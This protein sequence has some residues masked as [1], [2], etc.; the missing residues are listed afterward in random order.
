MPENTEQNREEYLKHLLKNLPHHPG[1]YKMKDKDGTIIYVGKAKDLKN[2]V[3]SYFNKSNDQTPKTQKMV[4]QIIDIDYTIVDSELEA[5]ILE[6]N[7]IKELRPKYNI[8]MKDDKN[9][10]YI[11]IT[12]NEDFPRIMI[13]R[14]VLKDKARYFG[15]KTAQ[16]KVDSLLKILKKLFPYRHCQLDI[17]YERP[18]QQ[19]EITNPNTR[20][21]VTVSHATIK[22]P[23]LDYHIKRCVGPCIGT[24]SK[25]EY[26]AI[27]DQI[28]RFL[29][30]KQLEIIDHIKNQMMQAAAEKKFEQAAKLRDKLTQIEELMEKQKIS[31]P[32]HHNVDVIG[33]VSIDNRAYF[34][35]FQ[36][37][38]GK[39][40]NQENFILGADAIN[41]D[42]LISSF[43]EQY[44]ESA[45]D[46]PA[47][48]LIPSQIDSPETMELWLTN[49][50]GS[51]VKITVPQKGKKD[52][53]LDLSYKNAESYAK[54]MQVKWQGAE[55]QDRTEALKE[56]Q[57]ILNLPTPPKRMECY[58][59]SHN[60]GT[61]TVSSMVVFENG[62][63]KKEDYRRFRLH[64]QTPGKPDDFASMKETL[65]R[66]LKY[67]KPGAEE[68]RVQIR[69]FPEDKAK[70]QKELKELKIK[71]VKNNIYVPVTKQKNTVAALILSEPV[72]G[73]FVIEK[74]QP[75]LNQ[76]DLVLSVKK[77]LE[78]LKTG[79]IYITVATKE[80]AIWEESGFQ[81][82]YKNPD[83]IKVKSGKTLLV[84]DKNK[85]E[86][87]K[88][89]EQK[90]DLIII[91]G[92]KGQLNMA[93]EAAQILKITIPFISIAKRE[94]EIFIPGQ[95]TSLLLPEQSPILHLIEHLRDE[96]HR[97]AVSYHHNLR[98]HVLMSSSLDLI[99]GIGPALKAK[100]LAK[101]GSVENIKSASVNDLSE[102]IGPE[103]AIKLKKLKILT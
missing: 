6:T 3:S 101:Y 32:T 54:Q 73:K 78:K 102:I 55:K 24:V 19:G 51:K 93:V 36:I 12:V 15:P 71:P 17:N 41:D 66:R 2:R 65:S 47:E 87:D 5:L 57:K 69:K 52:N 58:D 38:E 81:Q 61:E 16:H 80:V 44:Y 27:I 100:L 103:K 92:G 42:E 31:E 10:V 7:L 25:E 37:R 62:F 22:Y 95:K 76:N 50:K 70:I 56:L 34:N 68:L 97:F 29:E 13:V 83:S 14:K 64:Q 8:L 4:E 91:D 9:Y 72:K 79:R 99:S 21:K 11:K 84:F 30:G 26:R 18:L 98:S 40:I 53:L 96:A 88:S 35:L 48:I 74:I 46:L 28:I 75:P 82:I 43:L 77:I 94:E 67:L 90:P 86:S 63:P 23:C 49:M 45:T 60:Q 33:Y 89:F 20:H 85:Y 59:I 39:L 1:V